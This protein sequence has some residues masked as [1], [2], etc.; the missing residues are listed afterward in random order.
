MFSFDTI[1]IRSST[2]TTTTT[3]SSTPVRDR[4]RSAS[5]NVEPQKTK[6]EC[7]NDSPLLKSMLQ[8]T[9]TEV[10]NSPKGGDKRKVTLKST[11]I[12]HIICLKRIISRNS[13]K[14]NLDS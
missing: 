5:G 4:S 11:H 8:S 6:L 12:Q 13:R 7:D 14:Q 9:K 10:P 3:P 2:P 1:L